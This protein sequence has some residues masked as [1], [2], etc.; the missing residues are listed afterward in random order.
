M[1]QMEDCIVY[2]NIDYREE[3]QNW[4]VIVIILRDAKYRLPEKM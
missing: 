2:V 4:N 1:G 3:C